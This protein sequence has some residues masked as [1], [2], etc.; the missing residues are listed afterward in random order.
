[1]RHSQL[2]GN[3]KGCLEEELC[4]EMSSKCEKVCE[5]RVILLREFQIVG[6]HTRKARELKASCVTFH[7]SDGMTERLSKDCMGF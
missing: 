6:A 1:L 2:G 7:F 4:L 5:T 3:Y